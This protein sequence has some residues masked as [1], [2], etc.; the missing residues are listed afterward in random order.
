MTGVYRS[1]VLAYGVVP[2]LALVL[3]VAAG[4]FTYANQSTREIDTA[5]IQSV[6]TA[7]A[8]TIAILSYTPDEVERQRDEVRRLL[9][10]AFRDSYSSL[11]ND[12]VIPVAKQ[13]QISG[14]A[15]V[16]SAGSVSADPG[17]AV[18]LVFVKQSVRVGQAAPRS[19]TS[20]VEVT[21]DKV[22]GSWLIS[23]FTP[24]GAARE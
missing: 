5:R 24:Q 7:T 6:Q 18:V 15:T 16:L 4:F 12:D 14:T 8:S 13:Q 11:M 17:R 10:G 23:D 21:L 9:T 3:A 19:T 20:S 22:G 1:R 2:A